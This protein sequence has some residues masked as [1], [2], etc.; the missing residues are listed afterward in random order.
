M[1]SIDEK[2]KIDPNDIVRA[3]NKRIGAGKVTTGYI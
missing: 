1:G 3:V 2:T